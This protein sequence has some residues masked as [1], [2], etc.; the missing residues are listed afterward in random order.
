MKRLQPE[1]EMIA[2]LLYRECLKCKK[3]KECPFRIIDKWEKY[4][5]DKF[6]EQ[7]EKER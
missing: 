6:H 7:A 4:A 3:R 1:C 2:E 5:V